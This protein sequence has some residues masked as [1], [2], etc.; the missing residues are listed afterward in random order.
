MKHLSVREKVLY[1]ITL[2]VTFVAVI[3]GLIWGVVDYVKPFNMNLLSMCSIIARITMVLSLFS[4]LVN[5]FYGLLKK[6]NLFIRIINGTYTVLMTLAAFI[7]IGIL[8]NAKIT[9]VCCYSAIHYY[10]TLMFWSLFTLVFIFDELKLEQAKD[11][12]KGE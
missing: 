1:F 6:N 10:I 12:N 4:Y 8:V 3:S 2:F 5:I 11:F 9:N 7:T